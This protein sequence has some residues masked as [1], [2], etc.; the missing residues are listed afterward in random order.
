[1]LVDSAGASA[2]ATTAIECDHM[3]LRATTTSPPT[4]CVPV[5]LTLGSS[6]NDVSSPKYLFACAQINTLFAHVSRR[7]RVAH[8]LQHV[9]NANVRAAS[10]RSEPMS[11]LL[12]CHAPV[13]DEEETLV[14]FA[15]RV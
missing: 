6:R 10:E 9:H 5:A 3:S 14:W 12:Y 15:L 13:D 7:T 4:T 8:A 2:I 1:M 11:G